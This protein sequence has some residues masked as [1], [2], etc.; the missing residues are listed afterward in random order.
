[1]QAG[2]QNFLPAM[3]Q[4][5]PVYS[6]IQHQEKAFCDANDFFILRHLLLRGFE[7]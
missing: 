2:L 3:R 1:M 6:K 4:N 7:L 5:L